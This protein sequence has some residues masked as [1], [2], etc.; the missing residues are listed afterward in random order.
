MGSRTKRRKR[1]IE[2]GWKIEP[3]PNLEEILKKT[4]ECID[5]IE[6]YNAER[7]VAIAEKREIMDAYKIKLNELE[8]KEKE[9]RA[10]RDTLTRPK[11]RIIE[12]REDWIKDREEK[13]QELRHKKRHID[14]QRQYNHLPGKRLPTL[15]PMVS[16]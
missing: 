16:G 15:V 10:E 13:I 2:R 8:Q 14:R 4:Q 5:K 7:L 12:S 6:Q 3:G 11:T 9:L 1:S